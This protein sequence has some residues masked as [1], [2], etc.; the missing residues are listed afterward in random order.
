MADNAPRI[1]LCDCSGSFRPDPRA[2]EAATGVMATGR[3]HSHLCGAEAEAAV[4]A[5]ATGERL[6]IAC[7]QMEGFFAEIADELGAAERMTCIDIRD[8]AGWS[9]EPSGPKQ[10]ALVAGDR[11]VPPAVPLMDVTSEGLCLVYGPADH[12]LPAARR[13]AETLAVTVMLTD[14]EEVIETGEPFDIVTGRIRNAKG[15]LGQF[16][17][18]V[19]RFAELRQAGRG[20][21]GF[22]PARES[23]TTDCDIILDLS[24]GQ[25]L[26]PAHH[27]RDGYLRPDPGDPLAV[28]RAIFDAAQLS[29]SFERELFIR[30]EESLCAH[31]RAHKT[32]CTRC[33]DVCPT[34]AIASSG[35]DAVVLD[36]MVCAGCGACHAV[37]PS[38]AASSD[39]P[40]VA[41]LF[42]KMR[43]MAD[44]FRA[45]GGR[46]P[47]L[48]VHD[49]EHG[50]EM[51]RL[52]ARFGRGLPGDVLPLEV[53]ALSAFGHAEQLAA[54]ALGY[55]EVSILVGPCTERDV[56]AAQIALADAIS[57]GVSV[58][59]GRIRLIDP[60]EPDR[61]S[62]LLY[63]VRPEPLSVEPILASGGRR[64]T[65]RLAARA[66]AGGVPEAPVPLP[67]GAPYGAVLVNRDA[68][69]LCLSCAGLCPTGALLDNADRPELSFREEACIQCGLCANICP[70]DAIRLEPRL[71]L[72]D[73]VLVPRVM[74]EEEP[75]ACIEC[76]KL[77]GVKSTIEKITAKLQGAHW[78]FTNSDNA[79]LIQMCDDCRVRA[80]YH[81][82]DAPMRL[83]DRP[84]IR[85]T[86]DYLAERAAQM[87]KNGETR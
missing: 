31:S 64:D 87:K 74:N 9:D 62:D 30:F 70:E 22:G 80:Q 69:T 33:L 15:A 72:S 67:Q 51:I 45:A 52:A 19:A 38:G 17:V 40:P 43:V 16:S 63:A 46:A 49:G 44:A 2:I 10:A 11:L 27:K 59:R 83:G 81:T 68:C 61:L 5:L 58:S 28:E 47:R 6:I 37:C 32:G 66:L 60:A 85:T 39:D 53:R 36:P 8:R 78:M 84:R 75:F 54:L 4:A 20:A 82:A 71:D 14:P 26:F 18:T 12:A 25:P 34:G 21:R 29:G 73:A 56:I 7:G 57:G 24:G 35:G 42:R 48:L 13:L 79:R 1:L 55:S 23:M 65:V 41:F 76:G 77:F 86:E 3:V 50:G